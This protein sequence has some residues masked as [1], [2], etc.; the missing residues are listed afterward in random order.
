M[1]RSDSA[2]NSSWIM[3]GRG[4][5]FPPSAPWIRS[6]G[7]EP[8]FFVTWEFSVTGR[9]HSEFLWMQIWTRPLS[10]YPPILSQSLNP[11]FPAAGTVHPRRS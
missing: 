11:T 2:W 6:R 7:L 5:T 4:R 8:F 10:H 3:P 9:W 1:P